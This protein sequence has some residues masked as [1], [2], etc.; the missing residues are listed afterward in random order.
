MNAIEYVAR[1]VSSTSSDVQLTD[2]K[3]FELGTVVAP[4]GSVV[5]S[6]CGPTIYLHGPNGAAVVDRE[7]AA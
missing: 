4:R 1:R 6:P 5:L 3:G 7:Q 2:E